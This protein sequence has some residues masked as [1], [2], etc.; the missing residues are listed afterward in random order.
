MKTDVKSLMQKLATLGGGT[1]IALLASMSFAQQA[2]PANPAVP[3]RGEPRSE[4]VQPVR[5]QARETAKA[6]RDE[7]QEARQGTR[8]TARD[9][10]DTN[11]ETRQDARE[12][13]RENRQANQDIREGGRETS[14]DNRDQVRDSRE[15][16]R[17]TARDERENVA[18]ARRDLRE[19]R[20]EFRAERVRSGDLGLWVRQAANRLMISDI[21]SRGAVTQIGLKE[22]DQVISVNGQNVATE[23][24]FMDRLFANED[25]TKAVAV[26]VS[27]NGQQQTIQITPKTLAD[28]YLVSDANSLHEYGIIIDDSVPD[29]LR[30][31]AVVPR[32]P[33]YY[34]GVRS[35]DQ[36]TGFR[37]QRINAIADFVRNIASAAGTSAPLEVN[38][39]NQSRQLEIDV[40]AQSQDE[41]RTALRPNFQQPGA[42][43]PTQPVQPARPQAAPPATGTQPQ[44]RTQPPSGAPRNP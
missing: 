10:R 3:S 40:P 11:Q 30:V 2:A 28:E 5:E 36:I 39:N 20:R 13:T 35:G 7:V 24:E 21:A 4:Q 38:R 43:A 15:G 34:A 17:D 31:Q 8:S 23:R 16:R 1:L 12:L 19:S 25:Q 18:D 27:R 22:G 29:H 33:A 9:V 32:S 6:A 42:V 14:R 44:P 26:V 37:G 41:A